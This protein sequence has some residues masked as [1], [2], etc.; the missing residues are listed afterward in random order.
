MFGLEYGAHNLKLKYR[1][2]NWLE[3]VWLEVERFY[4]NAI[5]K[6][7]GERIVDPDNCQHDW[8][9]HSVDYDNVW[10]EL[11]CF[12]CN[13]NGVVQDPDS[14]EWDNAYGAS[15]N[16]YKWEDSSRVVYVK[17]FGKTKHNAEI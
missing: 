12:D 8:E 4:L 9:V 16:P 3:G 1:I 17:C 10:L 11:M 5:F 14:E 13:S 15:M 2:R 7:L 6:I